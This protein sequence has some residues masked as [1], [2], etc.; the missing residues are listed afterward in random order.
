MIEHPTVPLMILGNQ[1]NAVG[2]KH[3]PSW[4]SKIYFGCGHYDG[5]NHKKL[6]E[7]SVGINY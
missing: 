5:K 4:F 6:Q 3:H 1:M 7:F 2:G